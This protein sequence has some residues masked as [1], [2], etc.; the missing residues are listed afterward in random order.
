MPRFMI[1]TSM[2]PFRI[3]C[4]LKQSVVGEYNGTLKNV[5]RQAHHERNSMIHM[6]PFALSLS[7]CG[8]FLGAH[9]CYL[10]IFRIFAVCLETCSLRSEKA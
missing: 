6:T 2:S 3:H 8:V 9:K 7:K 4:T 1:A 10:P 5:V